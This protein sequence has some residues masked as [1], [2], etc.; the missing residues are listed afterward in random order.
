MRAILS[1]PYRGID[2][3]A[4]RAASQYRVALSTEWHGPGTLPEM[5]DATGS[6]DP[7][8]DGLGQWISEDLGDAWIA[9]YRFA[10]QDGRPVLAELHVVPRNPPGA[11]DLTGWIGDAPSSRGGWQDFLRRT[12]G[13]L[14]QLPRGGIS[15][16]TL[17]RMRPRSALVEQLSDP[18]HVLV[19][20]LAPHPD[21]QAL[22]ERAWQVT[23]GRRI[24]ESAQATPEPESR[25]QRL[26]RVAELYVAGVAE[27]RPRL[28]RD[29][30]ELTGRKPSQVR[31][32]IYAARREGLLTQGGGHGRSGGR[33]TPKAQ[34]ILIEL[35]RAEERGAT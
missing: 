19:L 7:A 30:A 26:A 27:A 2:K 28:N 12:Q 25:L 35:R 21:W 31:D 4:H 13:H 32:D 5:S 34:D 3:A 6:R 18:R 8:V 11:I 10:M 23:Q 15:A 33:L 24:H 9:L 14:D 22:A 20:S 17:R 29:I 16:R 1:R